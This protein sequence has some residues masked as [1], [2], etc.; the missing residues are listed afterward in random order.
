LYAKPKQ[1]KALADISRSV[2]N[3]SALAPSSKGTTDPL[4]N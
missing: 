2:D 3:M 1:R 4:S